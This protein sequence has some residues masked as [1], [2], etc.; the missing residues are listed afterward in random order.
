MAIRFLTAG[1]SH[2]IALNAILEGIPYGYELNFDFINSELSARQ[3]GFGRGGRMQIEKDKIKIKS[4]V[5]H[6]IT[7]ASPIAI[8]IENKD[9]QNWTFPMSVEKINFDLLDEETKAEILEKIEEKKITK[10]RPAHADL[11]GCIKYDFDDIRYVLERSSARETATRVAIGAICQNILKNYNIEFDFEI[12]QI[13][14]CQNKEEFETYIKNYQEQGDSLGG[15]IKLTIKN[16]P[17]GLGSFIHWDKRLDGKLAAA[18]MSIPAIKSVEVG[19]GKQY[20]SYS[21]SFSH[22][23]IYF[24]DNKHTHRTNN[25]GGIEGGMSNGEDII[26]TIAMKPIPTIKKA[27]NSIEIKTHNTIQAHFERADNC[28]VHACGVVAKNMSAIVILDEF[29][30]KFG[31]DTKRDIDLAFENYQKRINEI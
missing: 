22:D 4:G 7:T 17:I 29:L 23:E 9:W 2:G 5:R 6:A 19:L 10:F 30:E 20:A 16:V 13:G 15:I 1:E 12:L 8:E 31:K 11:A 14:T 26:L 25:S 18:L 21:G 27:L 28:A 3:E 24:K